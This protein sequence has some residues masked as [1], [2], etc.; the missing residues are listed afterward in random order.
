MAIVKTLNILKLFAFDA[1]LAAESGLDLKTHMMRK[2]GWDETTYGN[3]KST[4]LVALSMLSKVEKLSQVPDIDET[5]GMPIP[6]N[7]ALI[8]PGKL[9]EVL[10]KWGK[11]QKRG[12]GRIAPDHL[13]TGANG[14]MYILCSDGGTCWVSSDKLDDIEIVKEICDVSR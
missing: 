10:Y 6:G 4:Y 9:Y 7:L 11:G 2:H 13:E 8:K 3:M 14:T 1:L 5:N 12:Y